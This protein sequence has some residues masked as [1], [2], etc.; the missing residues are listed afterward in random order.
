MA[1]NFDRCIGWQTKDRIEINCSGYDL[2]DRR[3]DQFLNWAERQRNKGETWAQGSVVCACADFSKCSLTDKG[4]EVIVRVLNSCGI[5]VE[6]LK[7]HQN[8]LWNLEALFD[9]LEASQRISPFLE[10][11][12]SHNQIDDQQAARLISAFRRSRQ[13]IWLRIEKNKVRD[14]WSV[15]ETAKGKTPGLVVQHSKRC[16]KILNTHVI[17]FTGFLGEGNQPPIRNDTASQNTVPVSQHKKKIDTEPSK[18]DSKIIHRPFQP[19][20]KPNPFDNSKKSLL[21]KIEPE[22]CLAYKAPPPEAQMLSAKAPPPQDQPVILAAKSAPESP[23]VLMYKAPPPAPNVKASSSTSVPSP[24][25]APSQQKIPNVQP[26]APPMDAAAAERVRLQVQQA[27]AAQRQAAYASHQQ[28]IAVAQA[29]YQAGLMT[30]HQVRRMQLSSVEDY[31]KPILLQQQ[32]QL[33]QHAQQTL[34]GATINNPLAGTVNNPLGGT[35]VNNP[36]GGTVNNPLTRVNNPSRTTQSAS[37]GVPNPIDLTKLIEDCKKKQK[38]L[39]VRLPTERKESAVAK[40]IREINEA[41]ALVRQQEDARMKME[42][43]SKS[44]SSTPIGTPTSRVVESFTN[45][46]HP[47]QNI[48]VPPPQAPTGAPPAPP[49][50]VSRFHSQ[51]VP[52]PSK[53]PTAPASVLPGHVISSAFHIP[54]TRPATFQP[55]VPSPRP[56]QPP[57]QPISNAA[58]APPNPSGTVVYDDD[59]QIV[60]M[61]QAP[62]KAPPAPPVQN[63]KKSKSR[64]LSRPRRRSPSN[65]KR[66]RSRRRLVDKRSRSFSKPRNHQRRSRSHRTRDKRRSL[67]QRRKRSRSHTEQKQLSRRGPIVNRSPPQKLSNK[68]REIQSTNKRKRSRSTNKR[69]RSRSVRRSKKRSP[70][71]RPF[72]DSKGGGKGDEKNNSAQTAKNLP[73]RKPFTDEP[74]KEHPKY[75]GPAPTAVKTVPGPKAKAVAIKTEQ[76]TP[77]VKTSKSAMKPLMPFSKRAIGKAV[78]VQSSVHAFAKSALRRSQHAPEPRLVFVEEKKTTSTKEK[79][80]SLRY[81]NSERFE[82]LFSE[83][84]NNNIKAEPDN[85]MEGSYPKVKSQVQESD[86]IIQSRLDALN[87]DDDDDYDYL[88]EITEEEGEEEEEEELLEEEIEEQQPVTDALIGYLSDPESELT[89]DSASR[90]FSSDGNKETIQKLQQRSR[91]RP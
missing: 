78:N 15:V 66:S 41:A 69:K 8:K 10:L 23:S 65:R 42:E 24:P 13:S 87:P 88:E 17:L 7:L 37:K 81:S 62:K 39:E 22:K 79:S 29:Q 5:C 9:Y 77:T 43:K 26:L 63:K 60:G 18:E 33:G 4:L 2:S 76:I 38:E 19:N 16:T 25:S 84:I 3:V 54:P 44:A 61:K 12:L 45:V 83:K 46:Q 73:K 58:K 85:S 75:S 27:A 82:K 57:Q 14:P 52:P 35:T 11:H 90:S 56:T 53:P 67:S 71:R 1:M 49:P 55:P 80:T 59:V 40:H 48:A 72:T 20:K 64:S 68:T 74:R 50:R 6:R 91:T 36:L 30:A 31:L 51:P 34:A 70:Q 89:R 32:Q 21:T 86:E 28:Q 47:S